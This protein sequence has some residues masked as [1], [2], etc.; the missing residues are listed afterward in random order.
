MIQTQKNFEKTFLNRNNLDVI[1]FPNIGGVDPNLTRSKIMFDLLQIT[2]TYQ[3]VIIE[4]LTIRRLV[5]FI[6][7][8]ENKT[9][10]NAKFKLSNKIK[11][12]LVY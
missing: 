7:N 3:L 2:N 8:L 5:Y 11:I 12:V 6:I 4:Y 1:K 9:I 10:I